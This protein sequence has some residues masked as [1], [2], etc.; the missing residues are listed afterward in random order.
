M[1]TTHW[2]K[3]I[4]LVAVAVVLVLAVGASFAQD[5]D[6]PFLGF[7]Y[8]ATDEG[9]LVLRVL[10]D[11]PADEAGLQEGDIV[12]GLNGE[13]TSAE[14]FADA[15]RALEIGD[16]VQL[17]VTRDDETLELT[18]TLA[19]RN[20]VMEQRSE[21]EMHD[22]DEPFRTPNMVGRAF[23]GVQLDTSDDGVVIVEVLSD[24]PAERAELEV[25][26][27]IVSV[28]EQPVTEPREVVEMIRDM[29]AGDVVTLEINR[30][31][32]TLTVEATLDA[33]RLRIP[34]RRMDMMLDIVMYDAAA[35]EWV[36]AHLSES[37]ALY[38]AGLR[39]NDRITDIEGTSLDP[40][41]LTEYLDTLDPDASVTV[42]VERDGET[43][44]IEVPVDA[45]T[46]L[47]SRRM[48][49]G[50]PF[51]FEMVMPMMGARLGVGVVNLNAETAESEGVDVTEG[52]LVQEVV[53]DSAAEVAGLQVGDIITAVNGEVVDEEHTLRDR[54]FAYEPDDTVT[55]SVLRDGE[56]LDVEA[57]LDAAE[58]SDF[59]V[60][61]R[62][63]F[64][65]ISI[66]PRFPH[67]EI[68]AV[69]GSPMA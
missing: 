62:R 56:T 59:F 31:G 6:Q 4:L 3:R 53:E 46:K 14:D 18:A 32:E 36:I 61:G 17:S 47:V 5:D 39:S 60:P 2:A 15:I 9:V 25:G 24:S 16:E 54:L 63:V 22:R 7:S 45:L 8:E 50:V 20:E 58:M 38:E 13:E 65:D 42:T 30:D 43:Q 1:S 12:T 52:A 64:P 28:D 33:S 49:G 11:S 66:F 55:L 29:S 44:E 26:D 48:I 21:R 19:S 51:D 41:S 67:P 68:P 23:L 40:A 34:G 35:D 37:N 10:P 57:T 27:V 69:P